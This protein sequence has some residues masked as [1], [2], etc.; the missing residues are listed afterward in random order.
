[1]AWTLAQ[2]KWTSGLGVEFDGMIQGTKICH[3][4]EVDL[5]R[6]LSGPSNKHVTSPSDLRIPEK[7]K[8]MEYTVFPKSGLP[9]SNKMDFFRKIDDLGNMYFMT[10][11][12]SESLLKHDS[13][14]CDA[15]FSPVRGS[16]LFCQIFIISVKEELGMAKRP[17]IFANPVAWILMTGQTTE[18]YDSLFENVKEIVKKDQLQRWAC[19]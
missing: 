16:K 11:K 1:M 3:S 9:Y 19:S 4:R 2:E 10:K 13:I 6:T 15:T 8:F 14:F 5:D 17:I 7:V 18:H 12:D